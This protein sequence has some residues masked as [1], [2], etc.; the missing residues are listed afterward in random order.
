VSP[1]Y[2]YITVFAD[3]FDDVT[4]SDEDNNINKGIE[5]SG[6]RRWK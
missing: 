4:E 5:R 1:G 2:Y 3:V 6:E